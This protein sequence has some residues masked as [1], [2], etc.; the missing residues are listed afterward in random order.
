MVK[1]RRELTPEEKKNKK[2][3]LILTFTFLLFFLLQI[4]MTSIIYSFADWIALLL[5]S[6]LL[7]FPAYLSNAGMV[8]VGGGKPIDGGKSFKN[9]QRILGDHKTWNGLIKG[10]LYIGIPISFGVFL[11][12]MALWQ[13]IYPIPEAMIPYGTYHFYNQLFYYEYYF[14]GGIFPLGML[15]LVIRIIL[16]S[17]GAAIGDLIGSFIKRRFN[18]KSGAPFWILDQLDFALGSLI[19]L[20]IPGLLFPSLFLIPDL[21]IFIFI[22]ILTPAVSLFANTIAYLLGLKDVPW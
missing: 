18:Y 16:S 10:P 4:L 12:L 17:Y 3:A 8:V 6:L 7:I 21:N 5:F 14:I 13:F 22:I 15:V 11:L 1:K 20:I 19:F 2:I 9:G